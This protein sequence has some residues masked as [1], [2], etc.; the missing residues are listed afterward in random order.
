M[1]AAI[2]LIHALVGE[3]RL[4]RRAAETSGAVGAIRSAGHV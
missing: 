3:R 4:G 1:L 2:W